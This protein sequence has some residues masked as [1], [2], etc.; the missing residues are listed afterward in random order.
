MVRISR[1]TEFKGI[2][3]NA[4]V[5]FKRTGHISDILWMSTK[6]R[7]A[8]IKKLSK[9]LYMNIQTCEVRQFKHIINRSEDLKSVSRSL[10]QG[11]DMINCN[12]TE[13]K[14]CRWI[15][16]TYSE[17]MTDTKRLWTNFNNFVRDSRKKYGDFE[18]ITAAEPQGRGA[19]HMHMLMLFDH[20]APFLKNEDINGLWGQGFVTVKKLDDVDNV[21]AYLTA[22]LGDVAL[23]EYDG[24]YVG[25]KGIK[26]AKVDGKEK[27][28]VK[29]GRLHMYPPGMHIFRWSRGVKR[30]DV[31]YMK[32]E[33]AKEKAGSPQPTYTESK[34]LTDEKS[35]FTSI[36]A[37]EYYNTRR[38]ATCQPVQA[39]RLLQADGNGLGEQS[40][41]KPPAA[42]LSSSV[43]KPICI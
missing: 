19:W 14:N 10:G 39:D 6:S 18:Y 33:K 41:D 25:T 2:P 21:G 31:E 29:G 42:A 15:T 26:I 40:E 37:H 30:P 4:I 16:L 12:V 28:Y 23:D 20:R 38:K 11:R 35:G 5:R 32:Y 1:I 36:L 24:D 17:N 9:E 22:Y 34:T 13:P 7:G 27:K 3:K 8:Q 43:A